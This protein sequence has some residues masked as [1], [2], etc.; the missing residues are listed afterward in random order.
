[1]PCD[2]DIFIERQ[3]QI[4]FATEAHATILDQYGRVLAH[5]VEEWERTSQDLSVIRIVQR[6]LSRTKGVM[7]FFSDVTDQE[8]VAGFAPVNGSGWGVIAVFSRVR[9]LPVSHERSN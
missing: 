3:R 4:N 5:P 7:T 8:M 6:V 2:T 1:M 9:P